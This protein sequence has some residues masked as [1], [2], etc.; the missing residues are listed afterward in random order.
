[1]VT[2]PLGAADIVVAGAG[3]VG[4][5]LAIDAAMRGLEVMVIEARAAGEPP[6]S[7][8]N[9]VASRTLEVFRRFGIADALRASGLPDDYPTDSIYCASVAGPEITRIAMPSRNERSQPGFDDSDWPTPEPV[10]RVSQLY[11]E[12]ILVRKLLSLPNVTLLNRTTVRG[13]EQTADGVVVDC[14][15][16]DGGPVPVVGRYL[17]GC[18]GGRS[19]IRKA[20]G[21]DLVGDAELGRTRSSLIRAPGVLAL[22]DGRRP[23]WMSWVS[24]HKIRGN[25]IAINGKDVWLV[26]RS[27]PRG[28]REFEALDFDQSIRDVLG[29]GP[30][31]TWDVLNHEDWVGRR[32]VAERFCDRNVFIAGD[33]AH[34]WVPFAGYGMNAGIADAMSLSWLLSS[35]C[36]GW[37]DPG[38][39]DA[40]EAERLP[41]TDQVSRLAIGKV[42]ENAAAM[43]GPVPEA[44][45]TRTPEGDALRA[46]LGPVLRAINVPQFAPAGLNFG[47]YYD[48]SP[49]IAYD[50]EAAPAYDMGTVTASTV[51]GCRMPHFW[52]SDGV[53]ICDQLGPDYT[54]IRF[55]PAADI[56]P[57]TAAAGAA[58]VP[59]AVIDCPRPADPPAFRHAL[60]LVR[61]DQHVAW[62]GDEAP[63]DAPALIERLRGAQAA[64]R[65][66]R[67]PV[68]GKEDGADERT[69]TSTP[70]GAGT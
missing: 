18:D 44:L 27:L 3:P 29:V 34:L 25:L 58:G 59:M 21:V 23:A 43:M 52:R 15:T 55:D 41:I 36:K 56:R 51:P 10:V 11:L 8:C 42:A 2:A 9:T 60:I 39:L 26:H 7:K 33:A 37:A 54:L 66:T 50:G 4:M 40:Y 17:V 14:Q 13:Y 30:A 28:V 49:I 20:M 68:L 1:M 19:V 69:R 47:Y 67:A 16:E 53:S 46:T 48:A 12:P 31:L 57:L 22:F 62:R 32:L 63:A 24:N 45:S 38:M 61:Q 35:V 64:A 70:H 5:C 6:S 65:P